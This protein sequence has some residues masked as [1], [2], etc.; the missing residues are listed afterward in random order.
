[1]RKVLTDEKIFLRELCPLALFADENFTD[2]V[3]TVKV[4]L[5]SKT[6]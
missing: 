4:L 2:K 1:M 5:V 6:F 3:A